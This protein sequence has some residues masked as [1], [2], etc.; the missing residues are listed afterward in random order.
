MRQRV[1]VGLV[2]RAP[3]KAR[4][5][6]APVVERQVP[7]N[8]GTRLADGVVG[9]QADS[10]YVIDRHRCSTKRSSGDASLPSMLIAISAFTKTLMKAWLVNCEP[11]TPFYVSSGDAGLIDDPTCHQ[12]LV[13]VACDLE[14]G[15]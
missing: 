8:R 13:L 14:I 6:P 3:V 7:A 10:S 11:W 15:L 5:G 1:E 9:P 2:G 4:I 12:S